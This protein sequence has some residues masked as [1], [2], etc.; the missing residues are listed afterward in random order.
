MKVN[1]EIFSY[2]KKSI[3]Y[4][5][6]QVIPA[7]AGT[8]I[9]YLYSSTFTPDKYG[10]YSIYLISLNFINLI[11]FMWINQS[12]LRY[13]NEYKLKKKI[14]TIITTSL[15]YMGI[16]NLL[17]LSITIIWIIIMDISWELI[18]ICLYFIFLSYFNYI[19]NLLRI[20]QKIFRRSIN[21][22]LFS[23]GHL[24]LFIV[25]TNVIEKISYM[26]IFI[27]YSINLF[28]IIILNYR[29]LINKYEY[30]SINIKLLKEIFYYGFPLIFV[31]F[32]MSILSMSDRYMILFYIGKE[33]VGI[34]T[35]FYDMFNKGFS[36]IYLFFI[37]AGYPII[38]DK[39]ENTK[40]KKVISQ[41]VKKMMFVY[42]I[43]IIPVVI[44][45]ILFDDI[46]VQFF[47][48]S[49]RSGGKIIIWI[50]L[51]FALYGLTVFINKGIE[52]NKDTKKL[53]LM[54]IASGLINI[55]LNI[56]LIPRYG[57]EGAAIATFL[58]Y[59]FYFIISSITSRYYLKW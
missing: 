40:S 30:K 54:V 59:L 19:N 1:S 20:E 34:Y 11:L 42:I 8:I 31:A 22:I 9:I 51:G 18:V 35:P 16:V 50:S 56:C 26:Y 6:S 23:I 45:I 2:L 28:I 14:N 13:Y 5:P 37:L 10:T 48:E 55:I 17:L 53:A 12:I 49:Y 27:S 43:F 58:S 7:I 41:I 36:F 33:G 44:A 32:F 4:L 15:T 3:F 25:L 38:L 21:I 39:W 57:I 24:I 46:L 47:N 29:I 52:L